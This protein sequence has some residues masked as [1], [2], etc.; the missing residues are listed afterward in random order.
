MRTRRRNNRC[1]IP[2]CGPPP[3]DP[4]ARIKRSV[5]LRGFE[6]VPIEREKPRPFRMRPRQPLLRRPRIVSA[7]PAAH[8]RRTPKR[9]GAQPTAPPFSPEA[10]RAPWP[11][12]DRQR[13]TSESSDSNGQ[14]LHIAHPQ[15][16]CAPVASFHLHRVDARPR[17]RP[18]P[19]PA[20]TRCKS[21]RSAPLPVSRPLRPVTPTARRWPSPRASGARWSCAKPSRGSRCDAPP[22][23]GSCSNPPSKSSISSPCKDVFQVVYQLALTTKIALGL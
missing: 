10:S 15:L 5:D 3:I 17:P 18:T 16:R 2:R 9:P 8:Y 11:K 7:S 4:P 23:S 19:C 6:H 22:G 20:H 1:G 21:L 12:R 13:S 14:A